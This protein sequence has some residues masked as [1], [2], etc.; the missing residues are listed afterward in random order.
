[1]LTVTNGEIYV[2]NAHGDTVQR[3]EHGK[4]VAPNHPLYI[5]SSIFYKYTS[6]FSIYLDKII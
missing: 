1:M 5:Q 2:Y 4:A 6:K 3:D